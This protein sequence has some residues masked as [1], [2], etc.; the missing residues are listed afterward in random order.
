MLQYIINSTAIWL[1]GLL[2]FDTLL[3][4][5]AQHTYN[6]FYLLASLLMGLFIPLWSWDYDAIIYTNAVGQPVAEQSAAI[7]SAMV[8][9]ANPTILSWQQWITVVYITG[10]VILLLLTLKDILLIMR[11]LRSGSKSKDG[12]W[13]II[14]TDTNISPFSAFRYVFISNK[15]NYT[16]EELSMILAHEE[17]HGHQLHFIDVLLTRLSVIIFWFNPLVYIIEKRLL[18]VHEYQADSIVKDDPTTYSKFL[19]E[20]SVLAAAPTLAHSFIRSPLKK[21]ITMLTKKT[22]TNAKAKQLLI[23]PVLALSITCFAQNSFYDEPPKRDGTTVVYRGNTIEFTNPDTTPDTV[24]VQNPATGDIQIVVTTREPQPIL[25]N[26]EKIYQPSEIQDDLEVTNSRKSSL[27]SVD[28]KKYL[29]SNM[30][31]EIEQLADGEYMMII[32]DIVL[33][34]KGEIVYFEYGGLRK[35]EKSSDGIVNFNSIPDKVNERFAKKI[36]TLLN[37]APKQYPAKHYQKDVHCMIPNS[38]FYKSFTVRN[39]K[40]ATF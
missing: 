20:Q 3:R 31:N 39:K 10:V 38:A 1:I 23:V 21:R 7:K 27:T 6:R 19:I 11:L 9:A 32:K 34:S 24:E 16:P 35:H 8:T 2:V 14:E 4:K 15:K 5:E 30:N 40:L 26:N 18:M 36:A 33:S 28:L 22:T 12:T 25:L 13:T 17:Q 37:N 29:L